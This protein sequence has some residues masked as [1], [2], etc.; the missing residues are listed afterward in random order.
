MPQSYLF[1]TSHHPW[2][3]ALLD[4]RSEPMVS[5]WKLQVV[6]V[7]SLCVVYP[8]SVCVHLCVQWNYLLVFLHICKIVTR[9]Y[10]CYSWMG[11]QRKHLAHEIFFSLHYFNLP[12]LSVFRRS[13]IKIQ[14]FTHADLYFRML[15]QTHRLCSVLLHMALVLCLLLYSCPR[16]L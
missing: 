14:P 10:I 11:E 3:V 6:S 16:I 2:E 1:Q 8:V 15:S 5:N 7:S 13:V 9:S 4:H 12:C